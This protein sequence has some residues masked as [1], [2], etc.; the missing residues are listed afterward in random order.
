VTAGFLVA[1]RRLWVAVAFLAD[2]AIGL[3]SFTSD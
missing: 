1:A 3:T 2:D